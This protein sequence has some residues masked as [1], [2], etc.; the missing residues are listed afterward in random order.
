MGTS[1]CDRVQI[2]VD[3]WYKFGNL[4]WEAFGHLLPGAILW[5]HV[6]SHCGRCQELTLTYTCVVV[7]K[8][9]GRC[10]MVGNLKLGCWCFGKRTSRASYL[11]DGPGNHRV[12]SS[13][14]QEVQYE[15][16]DILGIKGQFQVIPML[17][18][19][20]GLNQFWFLQMGHRFAGYFCDTV[21]GC[22]NLGKVTWG[23]SE[24]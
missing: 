19:C 18:I 11:V 3:I 14:L 21:D 7:A 13:M 22:R 9:R 16:W 15:S 2:K 6:S 12:A 20:G 17:N 4:P 10:G 5:F 8:G 24:R 23:L 1:L